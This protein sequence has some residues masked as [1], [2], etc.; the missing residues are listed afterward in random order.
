MLLQLRAGLLSVATTVRFNF[1][2]CY[3]Y[4]NFCRINHYNITAVYTLQLLIHCTP[5][6]E[7]VRAG[8]AQ[9]SSYSHT[10]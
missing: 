8:T 5:D 1:N 9:Q 3:Q 4:Y 7:L 10:L 6:T 2:I